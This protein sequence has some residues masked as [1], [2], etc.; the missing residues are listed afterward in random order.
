MKGLT[1]ITPTGDRPESFRLW[2]CWI[3]HQSRQPDAW[4]VLDDGEVPTVCTKGQLYLRRVR[5]RGDP[6]NTMPLNLLA[7]LEA[8]YTDG[9]AI[10]EDDDWYAQTYLETVWARLTYAELVGEGAAIYYHVGLPGWKKMR[11]TRHASLSATAVRGLAIE[12][13]RRACDPMTN[14]SVDLRLWRSF[15]GVVYQSEWPITVQFKGMPG[16]P[17]TLSSHRPDARYSPDSG[18]S[19]LEEWIGEAS[20]QIR[21]L[22]LNR[23]EV[24]GRIGTDTT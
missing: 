9:L 7:A 16:R 14:P 15:S 24:D 2:E 8:V 6:P 23:V 18:Y 5:Q 19:K 11:N 22:M 10:I 3:S 13:L 21:E 20:D 17:G 4:I 1:L 12:A